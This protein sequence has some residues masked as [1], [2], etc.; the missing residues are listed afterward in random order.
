MLSHVRK[1]LEDYASGF[2]FD[3]GTVMRDFRKL[4]P[5][6]QEQ[7]LF[8]MRALENKF[9]THVAEQDTVATEEPMTPTA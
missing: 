7:A 3:V 6:D 5:E 1:V 9:Q 2:G 4:S 8:E